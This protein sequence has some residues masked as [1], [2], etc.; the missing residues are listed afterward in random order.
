MVRNVVVR[1][2]RRSVRRGTENTL[3]EQHQM[4]DEVLGPS[5]AC[6]LV[7]LADCAVN[8]HQLT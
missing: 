6:V 7:T 2:Q 8:H 5:M 4:H 1:T 3:R